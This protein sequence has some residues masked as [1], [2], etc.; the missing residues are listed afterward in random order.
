MKTFEL[1]SSLPKVIDNLKRLRLTRHNPGYQHSPKPELG[2]AFVAMKRNIA[3]LPEVLR[4]GTRLGA[5]HFSISNVLPHTEDLREDTV[6]RGVYSHH[7]YWQN[8][9][10]AVINMPRMDIN[11]HTREALSEIQSRQVVMQLAGKPTNRA[12]DTCPFIEQGSTVVRWD[13]SVSPCIPL[14]HSSGNFIGNYHRQTQ[15]HSIGKLENRGL[16]D[17]WNDKSYLDFR[18]KVRFFD[19]SPCTSCTGC[20]L[21]RLNVEDCLSSPFPTCGGCLYGQGLIQCP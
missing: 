5:K 8:N 19:F 18:E 21:S 12:L 1:G 11:Q 3:D 9:S 17:L 20:D 7:D 4:L 16:L 15:A 14:L 10:L 13:G 2:I 6:F